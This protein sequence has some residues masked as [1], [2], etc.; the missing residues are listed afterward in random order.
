VGRALP[1]RARSRREHRRIAPLLSL[2]EDSRAGAEWWREAVLYEIYPRSFADSNGDG[3]G[4][5]AGISAHLEYLEWL[6]VDAIWLNPTF[7]SPNADWGYDVA[8]YCDVDSDLGTLAD[9]DRLI[10]D[11]GRRRIRILLDLVPNHTSGRHPWFVDSRSSR[12]SPKRH[13]YI[14]ADPRS[15]GSPPNNWLST[16]GGPGWTLDGATGQYYHHGFLPEQPDLNWWSEDVRDEFDRILRFWLDRGVAGFRIDVAHRIVKDAQLR[17]NAPATADDADHIRRV[18]QRETHTANQPELHA[19]LRRWRALADSHEPPGLLLGETYVHHLEALAQ[20]YGDGDEL[21]LAFNF[22]FVHSAFDAA[23]SAVVAA[24]E[25]MLPRGAL[26]VWTASNHDVGR[27]P[28]RWCGG[29][30][31]KIRAALLVLLTLRGAPVLYYGDEIGM[32]EVEIPDERLRDPVGLRGGPSER[33]RDPGRTPMQWRDG[34]GAGFTDRPDRAW[35]PIGDASARNVAVQRADPASTLHFCR[36]AIAL[37]R[38]VAALRVADYRPLPAWPPAW[39]WRRGDSVGV[40]L[41]LGDE[42]VQVDGVRGRIALGTLGG[43]TGEHVRGPLELAPW[44]GVV[45]LRDDLRSA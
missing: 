36:D 44:E 43:R 8:D 27:F 7:P 14:W 17:D 1:P 23:L 12:D 4:D 37:R 41:N 34:P 39:A 30:E 10:A 6:G 31:R 28:S 11:A 22:V 18:G 19:V 42:P 40:A 26:P 29:D 25:Q 33:G 9:L 3:I 35:L 21:H 13:W 45:T 16:F 32:T 15:D 20:F 2:R 5:L 24:T 38:K